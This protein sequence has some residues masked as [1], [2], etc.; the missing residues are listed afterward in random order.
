MHLNERVLLTRKTVYILW[1]QSN[2]GDLACFLRSCAEPQLDLLPTSKGETIAGCYSEKV[3][4]MRWRS[5]IIDRPQEQN[6][7]CRSAFRAPQATTLECQ[8]AYSPRTRR[9]VSVTAS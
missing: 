4:S 5:E 9:K 1:Q 8:L 6:S 7:G 3:T 2:G